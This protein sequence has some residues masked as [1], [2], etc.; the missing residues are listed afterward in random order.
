MYASEIRERTNE[1]LRETVLERR[2]ESGLRVCLC[3]RPGFQ[4]RYACFAT[5]FGSTDVRFRRHGADRWIDVPDGVAH[6]LEHKL[7]EEE[8]GMNAMDK[9]SA[10]GASSNAYTSFDTT[11]YLFSAADQFYENLSTLVDF[12]QSPH[13][14]DENVEKEKGIIGEEI[15]MSDDSAGRRIYFNLLEALY[16]RHPIHKH[17]LGTRET[18]AT[19]DK[20]LLY[21]CHRTF[22]HPQNMILFATGDLDPGEYFEFA[23][24]ILGRRAHEPL[25]ELERWIPE[26]PGSVRLPSIEAAMELSIPRLYLGIKDRDVGY[27]GRRL[28]EREQVTEILLE[29]LFGH[30]SSLFESLYEEELVDEGFSSSYSGGV[31][32][33]YSIIGGETPDPE[34]LDAR[35]RE[36]IHRAR[37]DG[38]DPEDFERQR[39]ATMG[40]L[41]RYFNSLE[42][43]ANHYCSYAFADI[44]LFDVI[45][46][47]HSIEHRDLEQRLRDHFTDDAIALSIL[48]PSAEAGGTT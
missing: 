24:R 12:V 14:T 20:E 30:G 8:D 33:G 3:P 9:F 31:E 25:G 5:D 16:H 45:D 6:F 19:I 26:E 21:E 40:S 2:H 37:R 4:K 13:F 7:F 48:R 28:F 34:R 27:G 29:I 10:R 39:R 47:L 11:N 1:T 15:G 23:D 35:I 46:V 44:D 32:V 18:I 43:I 17:I 22:Y 42:F 38:I 36:E 41:F